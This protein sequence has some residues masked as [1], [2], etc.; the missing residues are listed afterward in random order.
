MVIDAPLVHVIHDFLGLVD[1]QIRALGD[2]VEVVVSDD[3]CNLDQLVGGQEAGHLTVDP[4][5]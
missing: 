4:D 5:Q 3:D 2:D 1:D